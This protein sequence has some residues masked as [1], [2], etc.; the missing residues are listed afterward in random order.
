MILDPILSFS[1]NW[2]SD[3][4]EKELIRP[5]IYYNNNLGMK[6]RANHDIESLYEPHIKSARYGEQE[7]RVW[8]RI[9]AKIKE[10][11]FYKCNFQ[12][13]KKTR[14]SDLVKNL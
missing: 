4:L 5:Q 8:A 11:F 7:E 1:I 9:T 14:N 10:F 2:E 13:T 6:K 12:N 3:R